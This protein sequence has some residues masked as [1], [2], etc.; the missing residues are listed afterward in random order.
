[1]R[2][3]VD[4]RSGLA[5]AVLEQRFVNPHAEALRVS[6]L[7]PLP[8]DGALAGYAIRIG[9]RRITGEVDRIQAA[10]ERFERALLD[11]RS[12]GL[13]DQERPNFF[14]L[15]LGN[16]PPGGEVVA[17]LTI[18]QRLAW[19]GE[20]AWEWRFPTAVAPRY[21]GAEGRIPDAEHVMVDVA[22]APLAARA[23][24]TL[25][26]R[27]SLPDE[28]G[29]V[30]PS[31]PI[32]VVAATAG[33]EVSIDPAALDRDVVVRWHVAGA[34]GPGLALDTARP[35]EGHERAGAAYGLLT[36]VPPAT[37]AGV[38]V[39]PRDVIV[40]IDTSGSME[41]KPLAQ[42]KTVARA[43]VQSLGDADQLEM[44]AFA[45]EPQ[46]WRRAPERATEPARRAAL[47][48]LHGLQAGGATEMREAITR[49]LRPLRGDA[50][51]Q[52]LLVTDGLIGF[53]REIVAAVAQ[54]LPGGSRLH[55]VG[56][57]SSVNRALT[58]PAARAGR[59]LEVVLGVDEAVTRPVARLLA[60]TQAPVL[61]EVTLSGSALR[62][63][64]PAALPDVCAG[65]PLRA[66]LELS[67]DGGDLVVRGRTSAGVWEDRLAVPAN[68][69]GQGTAAVL[70]L[71]GREAVE[72]LEVRSAA[73][74]RAVDAEIERLGLEF[75]IATRLTS[76]VAVAEEPS[77]DPTRPIRRERMPHTLPHGMSIEALGLRGQALAM[78]VGRGA[79]EARLSLRLSGPVTGDVPF[80]AG[81]LRSVVLGSLQRASRDPRLQAR[82]VLRKGRVL[83]F[84]IAGVETFEWEPCDV[85]VV[86]PHGSM[87]KS[88]V[89]APHTT[90]PG[91]VPDGGTVRLTIELG[92]DGPAG[93]PRYLTI[94]GPDGTVLIPVRGA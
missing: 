21:L 36:V 80:T 26:V 32:T 50:Q 38:G 79:H 92:K 28:R 44:I 20:G 22:D 76:W 70:S 53:E 33:C 3:A 89:I 77:V 51:R 49:A 5:R 67:P 64:A 55:T 60:A 74:D 34:A 66:A 16:I 6:Y 13:V 2:L 43:L 83:T 41:G 4:A 7:M 65:A 54:D 27:D 23:A 78:G 9:S 73:G 19:L 81:V 68:A 18:D 1:V 52:V 24:V 86:W 85:T 69:P 84:E 40:L 63:Q 93:L 75:Q 71:Y 57:G 82:L 37:E 12:A 35:P 15:E 59:G 11:G 31:H 46:R 72:D 8:V 91:P 10:R 45:S 58:A 42:A 90:A 48:W 61:T 47:A 17:E 25:R 14:T 94:G 56:V 29:P 88:E 30:S 62:G 39:L 87:L